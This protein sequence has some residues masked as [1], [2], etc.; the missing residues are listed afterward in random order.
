M[1]K[2]KVIGITNPDEDEIVINDASHVAVL[3]HRKAIFNSTEV[4]NAIQICGCSGP[5]MS[6]AEIDDE[7]EGPPEWVDAQG[8]RRLAALLIK[9]AEDAENGKKR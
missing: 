5:G 6:A 3:L 8:A 9:A 4:C 7:M 1:S 2:A